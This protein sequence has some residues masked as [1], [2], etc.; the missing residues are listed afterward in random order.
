MRG[1]SKDSSIKPM[2]LSV[3]IV[4]LSAFLP[5]SKA[6]DN[7]RQCLVVQT[8]AKAATQVEDYLGHTVVYV[9]MADVW[10]EKL[11]QH[12]VYRQTVSDVGVVSQ[13][14]NIMDRIMIKA[15]VSARA[16]TSAAVA[17]ATFAA[18]ETTLLHGGVFR[19]F[20]SED[21]DLLRRDCRELQVCLRPLFHDVP[22]LT[23]LVFLSCH[24]FGFYGR[25]LFFHTTDPK[26]LHNVQTQSNFV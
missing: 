1:A 5:S 6:L 22:L 14:D 9:T 20:S 7:R 8:L 3:N 16:D 25:K 10:Y 24:S 12:N 18:M 26:A 11:Y 13:L 23:F 2:G 4:I 21:A 19:N 15:S 17:R